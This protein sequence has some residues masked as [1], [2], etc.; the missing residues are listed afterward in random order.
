[1]QRAR[2]Y[3]RF[4]ARCLQEARATTDPRLKA[5]LAEMAQEWQRL[6]EEQRGETS[7]QNRRSPETDRGD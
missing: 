3:Q 1:M 6:V 2:M 7:R 4:V 5:I